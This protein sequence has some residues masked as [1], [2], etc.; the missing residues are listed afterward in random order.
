MKNSGCRPDELLNLRWKDIQIEDVG[1]ISQSKLEEEIQM[2]EMDGIDVIL[3]DEE[4]VNP[5]PNAFAT[6]ANQMGREE[7]LIAHIYIKAS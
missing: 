7:R 5:D 2:Y 3:D 4:D 6:S 1:R